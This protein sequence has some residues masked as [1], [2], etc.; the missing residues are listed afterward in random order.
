MRQY[1][2]AEPAVISARQRHFDLDLRMQAELQHRRRKHHGDVDADGIHP[3]PRQ[4]NVALDAG[5]RFFH[6]A[7]RIAHD[8]AAH[9]LIADA[10]RQHADA[11]GAG[12]PR[13]ARKL[14]QHRIVHVFEDFVDQL[15]FVMMRVDVDDREI[16]VA[17]FSACLEA[18]ASS[19]LVS[20]SSTAMRRKSD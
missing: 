6:A 7:R 15:A 19:L 1:A 5:F 16:L 2:L 18:C 8:A 12:L 13:A 9:V 17:A 4:R 3:A 20:N 14:L 10:G 11:F